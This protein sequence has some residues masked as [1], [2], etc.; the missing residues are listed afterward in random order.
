MKGDVW[1]RS[2]PLV[3]S[4]VRAQIVQDDVNLSLGRLPGDHLLHEGLKVGSLFGWRGLAADDAGGNLQR[5]KQV[6]RAVALVRAL[7]PLNDFAAAGL[8][9]AACALERL[10]GRLLIDAE[11][12][13]IL[14]WI[15]VQ[16]DHVGRLGGELR[17][18]A[19]APGAVALQLDAFFAQHA[20]H[21]II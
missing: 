18:R 13:G 20:P 14:R 7:H 17:I 4:L 11:H 6:D 1:V 16:P 8:N 10:D 12:Q 3:I 21:R 5:R 2:K 19:D 15:Q 9:V